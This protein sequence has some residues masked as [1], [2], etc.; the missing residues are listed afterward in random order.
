MARVPAL[1][2]YWHDERIPPDVE[3]LLALMK[4]HNPELHHMVFDRAKARSFI[5]THLTERELSAFDACAVPAMQADYFRYCAIYVLGGIYCDADCCCCGSLLPLLDD[6]GMLFMSRRRPGHVNNNVFAFRS[7]R[8]PLPKLAIEI[9]TLGIE[10]R[11]TESVPLVTGPFIFDMLWQ[12][13]R[14]DSLESF[15]ASLTQNLDPNSG[16]IS[17]RDR[18]DR[19][20]A[21]VLDLASTHAPLMDLF[22]GVRLRSLAEVDGLAAV[23]SPQLAYKATDRHFPNWEGSIYR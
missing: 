10:H 23:G 9:A 3:E 13:L 1:V 8:H 7:R 4:A 5:S 15:L 19:H 22:R 6:V 14:W 2:Q 11:F 18:L 16:V 17:D 20:I 21:A 12:A